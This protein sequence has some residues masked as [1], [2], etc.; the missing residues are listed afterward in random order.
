MEATET[1]ARDTA[2]VKR[3]KSIMVKA[4]EE[5]KIAQLEASDGRRSFNAV[6]SNAS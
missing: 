1:L 2:K 4:V 6:V 3:R 5:F